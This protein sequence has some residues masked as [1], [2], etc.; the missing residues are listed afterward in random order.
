[1]GS[2]FSKNKN[3]NAIYE[4]KPEKNLL[5]NDTST[6]AYNAIKNKNFYSLCH[7]LCN[8]ND[9]SMEYFDIPL[10]FWLGIYATIFT[11]QE[12]EH[13]ITYFK[14]HLPYAN[15]TRKVKS[16]RIRFEIRNGKSQLFVNGLDEKSFVHENF[17]TVPSL[18][19]SDM[20][21]FLINSICKVSDVPYIK[22]IGIN[23]SVQNKYKE[24]VETNLNIIH[25]SLLNIYMQPIHPLPPMILQPAPMYDAMTGIH[26]P[27]AYYNQPTQTRIPFQ[28]IEPPPPYEPEPSKNTSYVVSTNVPEFNQFPPT[29]PVA[30]VVASAPPI[31]SVPPP[32]PEYHVQKPPPIPP[33]PPYN[34]GA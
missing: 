1:M 16:F 12:L 13:V 28:P 29:V 33:Y 34:N 15:K 26:R 31:P 11:S 30:Q 24:T 5:G 20:C 8:S 2:F 22:Y 23:S 14:P 21:T 3:P 19:L 7:K 17:L 6:Y 9:I 27:I 32:T 10:M 4:P 25:Q 18:T